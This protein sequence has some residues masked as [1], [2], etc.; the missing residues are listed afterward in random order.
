MV[1]T[2]TKTP[3]DC[4]CVIH[5]DVYTW[6]YVERLLSM[7]QRNFTAPVRLHVFT[8]AQRAVPDHMIHH[9]LQDWP[10]ITGRRS[11]WWYKLQM[12]NCDN[13]SG[14][15]LYFDLDVMITGNLD[16]MIDLP[17]RYFWTIR[18][19]KR[20][21]RPN[22]QGINSSVMLWDTTRFHAVWEK[23]TQGDL[24]NITKKFK[25]DQD[26]LTDVID[27]TQ[28]RFFNENKVKSWRWEIKDGGMDMHTRMYRRPGAG[29]LIDDAT[30]IVIFHGR[31]KPHEIEDPV[32]LRHWA[33]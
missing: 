12:F 11:A 26:F 2:T 13:F 20:L 27:N 31:P 32:V 16:W 8:E 21:W 30:D 22:W 24:A 29:G 15:L 33:K 23:F 10:G 17:A 18:D 7:L 3:I 4:A 6:D 1:D 5:G 14:R 28:R 19:F 25:G 9:P